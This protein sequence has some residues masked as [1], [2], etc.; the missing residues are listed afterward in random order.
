[1]LLLIVIC[2]GGKLY[3]FVV[4]IAGKII[5]MPL[6]KKKAASSNNSLKTISKSDSNNDVGS[7]FNQPDKDT[8]KQIKVTSKA[9][10]H[11]KLDSNGSVASSSNLQPN[12]DSVKHYEVT[13]GTFE[14]VSKLNSEANVPSSSSQL[15]EDHVNQNE[16]NSITQSHKIVSTLSNELNEDFQVGDIVWTKIGKYPFWPSIVS[17]NPETNTYVEGSLGKF[18]IIIVLL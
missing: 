11:S 3:I 8:L 7:S 18:I 12:K 16:T 4:V 6:I 15:N 10:A 13:S 14:S 17:I 9:K 2:N 5:K 1:M